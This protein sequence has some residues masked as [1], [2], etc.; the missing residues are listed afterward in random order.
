[1]ASTLTVTV[2][3]DNKGTTAPRVMGNEYCVDFY[4]NISNYKT[5]DYAE[6][7]ASQI[8]LA[9]ITAVFLTGVSATARAAGMDAAHIAAN[10]GSGGNAG[11]Y[12]TTEDIA[13]ASKVLIV[14]P[15]SGNNENVGELRFRAFGY[16]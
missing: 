6:V 9:S 7:L 3:P 8:G 10:M 4:V 2:I 5:A 12:I 11:K 1:M 16:I 14:V 13:S 15:A